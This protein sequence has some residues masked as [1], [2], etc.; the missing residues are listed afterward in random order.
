MIERGSDPRAIRL[1]S[2]KPAWGSGPSDG[3]VGFRAGPLRPESHGGFL[4]VA[5][6]VEGHALVG[7]GL[8]TGAH[9]NRNPLLS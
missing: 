4:L 3:A 1:E 8:A 5:C 2:K 7:G 6:G 9:N